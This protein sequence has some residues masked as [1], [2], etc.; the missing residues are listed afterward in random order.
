MRDLFVF[1]LIA[2]SLLLALRKPQCGILV[3]V[4]VS[5]M[6]PHRLAYGWLSNFPILDVVAAVTIISV[7]FNS[8]DAARV[9]WQPVLSWLLLFYLWCCLTTV[10]S[11]S[12]DRAYDPW[13]KF[14]KSLLP[15]LFLLLYMNKRHWIIAA[16]AV[17]VL[18]IAFFGIKGGLFTV[19]T[20]G[21][22]R[23]YGPPK[24]SWGD[25]TSVSIAMLIVIPIMLAGRHLFKGKV[26]RN[27]VVTSVLI[28]FMALL[29]TQ[30]RGGFVGLAGQVM[31]VLYRSNRKI[32]ASFILLT[33]LAVGMVFMPDNWTDRMST[34]STDVS[35]LDES[36]TNRLIQWRYAIT[37]ANE[38]PLFGNGFNAFYFQPYYQKFVAHLDRNR[39]VHSNYFQVLGEQ[40]Y[41][42]IL[43]YLSM[44][45][46]FLVW[47]ERY[48]KKA[49]EY[50]ELKWAGYMLQA[51]Q[52]G[53]IGYAFNGLTVNMAYLDLA[54]F[55]LAFSVLL[56]S[57]IQGE[58]GSGSLGNKPPA[59]AIKR[60]HG[61][62]RRSAGSV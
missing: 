38:R 2:A 48:A 40:G 29:G 44:W 20:G 35:E 49:L 51:L 56:I 15:A 12:I 43:L 16:I 8:K 34:I 19:L 13:L 46:T 28:S 45:L 41:I 36:A 5:V 11:V 54:Y 23:V 26:Y 61:L 57:H 18:S 60:E 53:F 6:N 25:N 52:F 27:G 37:I 21:G 47:S 31:F 4:W 10:F 32:L 42:G 9:S 55:L 1:G 7:L 62:V 22:N 3:W 17:F 50:E 14:T 39:A 30:S 59:P 24:S 33:I 58:I